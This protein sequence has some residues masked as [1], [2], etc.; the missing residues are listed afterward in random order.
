MA[1]QKGLDTA[2]KDLQLEIRQSFEKIYKLSLGA[3]VGE[4]KADPFVFLEILSQDLSN[5][6]HKYTTSARVD[7]Q[8]VNITVNKQI[9]VAISAGAGFT[10][11]DGTTKKTGVGS[12]K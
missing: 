7:I 2:K 1:E 11:A 3:N 4:K 8:D 6:I 12:L 10:S 5:A 9:P